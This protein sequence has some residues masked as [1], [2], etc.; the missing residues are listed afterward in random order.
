MQPAHEQN[1]QQT[2][3]T[4]LQKQMVIFGPSLA[5]EKARMIPGMTISEDGTVTSV[6]RKPELIAKELKERF[7]EL[8]PFVVKKTIEPMLFEQESRSTN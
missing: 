3:T 1:Y 6:T 4:I 5:L 2:L 8:S 7:S